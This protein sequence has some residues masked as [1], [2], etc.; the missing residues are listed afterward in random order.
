MKDIYEREGK[1]TTPSE[2]KALEKQ[3][4][5]RKNEQ[6]YR[7][8]GKSTTRSEYRKSRSGKR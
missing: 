4:S 6:I 8:G 5:S 3:D 2:R 1:A 7:L